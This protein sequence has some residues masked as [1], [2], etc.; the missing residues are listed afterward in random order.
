[1]KDYGK[2]DGVQDTPQETRD[3]G[4]PVGDAGKMSIRGDNVDDGGTLDAPP[5]HRPTGAYGEIGDAR[6]AETGPGKK[7]VEVH[8]PTK[9]D[10]EGSIPSTPE[11]FRPGGPERGG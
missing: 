3:S 11:G 2:A 9:E 6:R 10:M 7:E 8:R 4:K 1:M 5:E